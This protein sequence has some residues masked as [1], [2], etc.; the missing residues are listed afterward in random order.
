MDG[1]LPGKQ[2]TE[3]V[4]QLARISFNVAPQQTIYWTTNPAGGAGGLYRADLSEGPGVVVPFETGLSHPRGL[5]G[6]S[7]HLYWIESPDGTCSTPSTIKMRS[8]DPAV[9]DTKILAKDIACPS[10]LVLHKGVLYFG[11]GSTIYRVM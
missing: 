1:F 8:S 5:V 9:S 2:M 6:D 11:V 10:N 3:D 7:V 4:E